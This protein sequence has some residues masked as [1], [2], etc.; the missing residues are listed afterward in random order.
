MPF[1]Q[2]QRFRLAHANGLAGLCLGRFLLR[3]HP[4]G[5]AGTSEPGG[6]SEGRDALP[7]R[8]IVRLPAIIRNPIGAITLRAPVHVVIPRGVIALAGSR[9]RHTAEQHPANHARRDGA[10]IVPRMT[11]MTVGPMMGGPVVRWPCSVSR[12]MAGRPP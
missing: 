4:I 3:Y 12:S 6:R 9:D 7:A 1:E 2:A 10:T 8:A 11:V 5:L